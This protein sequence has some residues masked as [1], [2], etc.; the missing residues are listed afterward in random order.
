MQ[1]LEVEGAEGNALGSDVQGAA[2]GEFS[3]PA[4]ERFFS[5]YAG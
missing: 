5:A 2:K 3:G 4:A 1:R